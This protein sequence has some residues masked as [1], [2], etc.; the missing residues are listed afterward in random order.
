M[1]KPAPV[2]L[3]GSTTANISLLHQEGS[4]FEAQVHHLGQKYMGVRPTSRADVM[5]ND[6][7]PKIKGGHPVPVTNFMNAQCKSACNG[8]STKQ[9][10]VRFY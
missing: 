5:F 9:I 3:S 10:S 7:L 6:N 4:S 1:K 2:S 8:K